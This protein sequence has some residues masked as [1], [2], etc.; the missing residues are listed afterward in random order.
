MLCTHYPSSKILVD[1]EWIFIRFFPIRKVVSVKDNGIHFEATYFRCLS[2][3]VCFSLFCLFFLL[4]VSS[5]VRLRFLPL[6]VWDDEAL[7]WEED[8]ME[9]IWWWERRKKVTRWKDASKD[10][11]VRWSDHP[12]DKQVPSSSFVVHQMILHRLWFLVV[13]VLIAMVSCMCG[14]TFSNDGALGRHRNTCQAARKRTLELYERRAEVVKR[15]KTEKDNPQ[16][17]EVSH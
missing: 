13:L 17:L 3:L 15:K 14:R 12:M 4:L 16:N 8:G 7:G 11:N 9:W 5:S 6:V 2:S 1:V 10:E